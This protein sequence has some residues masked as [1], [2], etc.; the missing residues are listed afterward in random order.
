MDKNWL[1]I[2]SAELIKVSESDWLSSSYH[3]SQAE[4]ESVFPGEDDDELMIV[5]FFELEVLNLQQDLIL[6]FFEYL[7]LSILSGENFDQNFISTLEEIIARCGNSFQYLEFDSSL[8]L[9]EEV[10]GALEDVLSNIDILSS[11]KNFLQEYKSTSQYI[12]RLV[13][14][15]SLNTLFDLS[16]QTKEI[17]G[18]AENS[19]EFSVGELTMVNLAF[20]R[21]DFNLSYDSSDLEKLIQ[22][23]DSLKKIHKYFLV[24]PN[25]RLSE[26]SSILIEKSIFLIRKF[27]IRKAQENNS[28][29]ENYVFLGEEIKFDLKSHPLIF[30]IFN[31]WDNY[32]QCHFLSEKNQEKEYFLKDNVK[33]ILKSKESRTA[34][35]IHSLIKYYKDLYP[36]LEQLEL[37]RSDIQNLPNKF[38]FD[39]YAKNIVNQYLE[40]NIF[41]KRFDLL[42]LNEDI[43][44]V[45]EL[46]EVD[47][48]RIE[49]FQHT[50]EIANFFPYFKISTFLV[51]FIEA[52]LSKNTIDNEVDS[53]S[54]IAISEAI[55]FLKK[56]FNKYRQNLKWSKIHL[57][58]AYQPPFEECIKNYTLSDATQ[59]NVFCSSTFSLPIDFGKYEDFEKQ[60]EFTILRFENQFKWVQ[61]ISQLSKSYNDDKIKLHSIIEDNGKKNIELLGIFSAI[62]ALLFQGAYTSQSDEKFE[63]KF[64]TFIVMFIVLISF[65]LLLRTFISNKKTDKI[66]LSL[67]NIIGVIMVPILL[68]VI[69]IL[70]KIKT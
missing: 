32:S 5:P 27:V 63:S 8:K 49:N 53:N 58:Y 41:S 67:I 46:I 52:R 45:S 51:E 48:K 22:Y 23:K 26:I 64:F 36:N 38:A 66:D 4:L 43:E 55:K 21:I 30:N 37:L 40:N 18:S 25:S 47:L 61:D 9:T 1:E 68:T 2:I 17:L 28:H 69:M 33:K 12:S 65:L 10:K 15:P 56:N 60:T 34:E 31:D 11:L 39:E 14:N 7:N 57:N 35:D 3:K 13:V 44:R 42:K 6:K 29:N 62:I 24:T 59:I 20:L 50:S 16:D 19:L 54:I 70:Y